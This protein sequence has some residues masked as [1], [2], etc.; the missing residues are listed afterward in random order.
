MAT[1]GR[2]EISFERERN[3][4][5]SLLSFFNR[6]HR[7]EHADGNGVVAPVDV[8]KAQRFL[9]ALA[10]RHGPIPVAAT[11]IETDAI[12]ALVM[13]GSALLALAAGHGRARAYAAWAVRTKVRIVVPSTAF[14]DPDVAAVAGNIAD[15]VPIYASTAESAT[16]VMRQARIHLPFDALT[17]ALASKLRPAAILTRDP[18][19][20]R[21]LANAMDQ[22]GVVVFSL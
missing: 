6:G 20:V 19:G 3:T 15:V 5:R 4:L 21:A 7:V 17:V 10:V 11:R 16:I 8:S 9:E 18:T 13:D 22:S 1:N 14:L 2:I 12:A